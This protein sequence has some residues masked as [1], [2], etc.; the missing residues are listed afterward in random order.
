MNAIYGHGHQWLMKLSK[1]RT[2][3]AVALLLL[4]LPVA[5]WAGGVVTNCTE[6]AL[7]AAITRVALSSCGRPKSNFLS[8]ISYG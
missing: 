5:A 3:G 7:R 6:A 4:P 2:R 8:V 1:R